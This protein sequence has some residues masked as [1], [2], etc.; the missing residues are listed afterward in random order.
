LVSNP[1]I[2]AA[3]RGKGR[4]RKPELYYSV[5]ATCQQI[6]VAPHQAIKMSITN[7]ALFSSWRKLQVCHLCFMWGISYS[8]ME[9]IQEL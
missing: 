8:E 9:N 4:S 1:F 5:S 2:I 3:E 6:Q 7:M